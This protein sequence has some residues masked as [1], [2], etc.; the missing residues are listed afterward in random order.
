VAIIEVLAH[1]SSTAKFT[2]T[3]GSRKE[4]EQA[5]ADKLRSDIELVWTDESRRHQ[6]GLYL[7]QRCLETEETVFDRG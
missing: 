2:V 6:C 1:K 7:W 4:A 3:A 5:I